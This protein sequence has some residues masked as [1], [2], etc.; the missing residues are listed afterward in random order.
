MHILCQYPGLWLRLGLVILPIF[1]S[2][3]TVC[4]KGLAL[5]QAWCAGDVSP[6][7][8]SR[9]SDSRASFS[10]MQHTPGVIILPM[11]SKAVCVHVLKG[12]APP[13]ASHSNKIALAGFR[14]LRATRAAAPVLFVHAVVTE[15]KI[16]RIIS[17]I[18]LC[19]HYHSLYFC[20]ICAPV[21]TSVL[22]C[23]L[24]MCIC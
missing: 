19:F 11:F 20:R 7:G 17:P 15:I 2:V 5:P 3:T 12:L 16:G 8:R 10:R 21:P 22:P 6:P 13:R 24:W 14:R 18:A 23:V 9:Q 4:A 1:F